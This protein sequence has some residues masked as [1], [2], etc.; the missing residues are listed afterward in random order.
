MPRVDETA[1]HQGAAQAARIALVTDSTCDLREAERLR[2]VTATVPLHVTVAGVTYLDRVDLDST[3]FYKL[4][5]E[6]DQVASSS[7]PSVGEFANVYKALLESHD[8]VISVHL[9]GR[10][11]GAVN[12]AS[13]AADAIDPN[14]IR[15]VDSQKV[16]VGVGLVVQAAG[17]AILAGME[18]EAVA[19]AAEAAA[20][21]TR[22]YG[23]L[24]SL[25]V[26][27]KGGRVNARVARLLGLIELKPL[28]VFD[29]EGG[30][31]VDGARLGYNRALRAVAARVAS[32]ASGGPARIAIVHADGLAAAQYTRQRLGS[33]LGDVDIPIVQAG[34]VITTHVG[35]GTIAVGVQRTKVPV[36]ASQAAGGGS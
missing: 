5:R 23:A 30:T 18:L 35:L 11:S 2:Y 9:S 29:E 8:A 26:A 20:R 36:D 4:F 32:F 3:G 28:I 19:A 31:H 10:L 14:R 7:Q 1:A 22:V 25:E 12:S 33:A 27:V 6:A 16:S 24:P 21:E 34:P 17:E 13:M 15:V